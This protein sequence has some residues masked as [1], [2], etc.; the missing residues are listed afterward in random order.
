MAFP[1]RHWLSLPLWKIQ[2]RLPP[3]GTG[4]SC[5]C[6]ARGG[7]CLFG[8]LSPLPLALF[9]PPIP[10]TP[11]PGGEGGDS[12]IILPGATAPGTPALNRLRHLQSLSCWCPEASL[13][14][15][16]FLPF[17]QRTAGSAPGCRG[18]SPRRNK[19]KSPPSPPGKG[20]GGIGGR[21]KA[22]AKVSRQPTGCAPLPPLP[23][24]NC[25]PIPREVGILFKECTVNMVKAPKLDA[26]MENGKNTC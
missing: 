17:G 12:K 26:V 24:K 1:R 21:N 3:G 11:F 9:L 14:G 7:A 18:R 15:N 6:G 5:R 25:P 22:K 8:R 19:L 4:Y 16:H 23:S 20:A 10:P 2:W 13:A